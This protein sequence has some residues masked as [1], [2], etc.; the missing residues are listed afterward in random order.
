[1]VR[2]VHELFAGTFTP[3]PQHFDPNT[4]PPTAPKLNPENMHVRFDQAASTV[5][6]HVRG[7]SPFPGTWCTWT[8]AQGNTQHCKILRT[9]LSSHR[10]NATVGVVIVD[11][12]RLFVRCADADLEIL[13]LQMEGRKRMPVA[14]FLRGTRNVEGS[15]LS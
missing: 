8:D 15:T 1:M 5:H 14:D 11:Q 3:R 10:S 7:M 4:P 6:D 13:E 2:T 9:A 12:D